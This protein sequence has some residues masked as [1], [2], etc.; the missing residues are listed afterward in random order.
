MKKYSY[1]YK[2][3]S[4]IHQKLKQGDRPLIQIT[5]QRSPIHPH[6]QRSPLKKS[7]NQRSPIHPQK[8][9]IADIFTDAPV[10]FD[11]FLVGS[12]DDLLL[13]SFDEGEYFSKLRLQRV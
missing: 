6:K 5:K 2:Q 12:S 10:K 8:T 13:S 4:P 1:S 7:I 11:Q 3:R 9:A